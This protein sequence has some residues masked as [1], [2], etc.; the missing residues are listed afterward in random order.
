MQSQCEKFNPIQTELESFTFDGE[1]NG[2]DDELLV[3]RKELIERMKNLIVQS[4]DPP[5]AIVISVFRGGDVRI[6]QALACFDNIYRILRNHRLNNIN[7]P[8]IIFEQLFLSERLSMTHLG[9]MWYQYGPQNYHGLYEN[10]N[11]LLF[12][13]GI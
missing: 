12:F 8:P 1:H 5:R 4:N 7:P 9:N 3:M 2:H 13:F 11:V 6:L 10:S